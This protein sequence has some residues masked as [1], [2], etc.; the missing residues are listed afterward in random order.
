MKY[1]IIYSELVDDWGTVAYIQ[2][3][4][5]IFSGKSKCSKED[6]DKDRFS[7]YVGERY[8]EIRAVMN[9]T[10]YK[11][12]KAQAQKKALEDLLIDINL[13]VPEAKTNPMIKRVYHRINQYQKEIEEHK[14]N[15]NALKNSIIKMDKERDEILDKYQTDIIE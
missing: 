6:L 3:R 13:N 9:W 8:A 12:K 2:T 11:Q 4:D 5:G 15:Y 10:K 1:R 7:L 14:N